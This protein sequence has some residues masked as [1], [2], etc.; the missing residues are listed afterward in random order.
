M[1]GIT[2]FLTKILYHLLCDLERDL[3]PISMIETVP[4]AILVR[5]SS[6]PV[7]IGS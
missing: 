3:V 4:G 5:P 7:R 1:M 6:G 2:D